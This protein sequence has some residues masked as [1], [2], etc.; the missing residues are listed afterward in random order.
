MYIVLRFPS[1]VENILYN[2]SERYYKAFEKLYG[3]VILS[4]ILVKTLI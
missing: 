3:I 4:S 2:E 1:T